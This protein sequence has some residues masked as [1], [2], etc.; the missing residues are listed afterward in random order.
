MDKELI[1]KFEIIKAEILIGNISREIILEFKN[2]INKLKDLGYL[3]KKKVKY[4]SNN[5]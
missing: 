2:I 5:I 1:S 3:N 4:I